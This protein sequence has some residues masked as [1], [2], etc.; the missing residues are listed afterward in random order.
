MFCGWLISHGIMS[1]DLSML[2][3]MLECPS[4]CPI[5]WRVCVYTFACMYEPYFAYPFNHQWTLEFPLLFSSYE[6]RIQIL[7]TVYWC[8]KD[9]ASFTD[10]QAKVSLQVFSHSH[11]AKKQWDPNPHQALSAG[12]LFEHPMTPSKDFRT[13]EPE[14]TR[15]EQMAHKQ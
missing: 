8:K 1:S 12:K 7:L 5:P 2:Q 13:E 6:H 3:H 15:R 11:I 10:G 9:T 14:A 4:F